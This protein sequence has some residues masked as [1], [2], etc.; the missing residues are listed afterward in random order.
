MKRLIFTFML[1][2]L[3]FGLFATQTLS[4]YIPTIEDDFADNRII[5]TLRQ[6]YSDVN[7]E[8]DTNSFRSANIISVED[9]ARESLTEENDFGGLTVV[10][11]IE[12]LMYITDPSKIINRETFTQI[13]L[14]ELREKCKENV[15]QVIEDLEKLDIVLAAEPYYNF[16]AEDLSTPNDLMFNQQWGLRGVNGIQAENA[17]D[18]VNNFGT[19][20]PRIKVGIFERGIQ[21]DHP[22][23]RVIPGNFT[24]A[25]NA[26]TDH[27]THVAGIIGAIADNSDGV[28][29]IAQVYIALLNR[30]EFVSS[31][32]WA[33][34]NDIRIVNASFRYTWNG[35]NAPWTVADREAIKVFGTNGGLLVPSA[36]NQAYNNDISDEV[37]FPAGYG[38][39]RN[40]PD[41]TNVITVGS[42]NE[43][44]QRSSF[45]N[46]GQNC[47]HIYAPGGNILST[48]PEDLWESNVPGCTQV[49]QG[50][51]RTSGT[52]M[53]AP[54]V[55][56]VAAL[57][58]SLNPYI[59]A[60]EIK[61]IMV[62]NGVNIN[63]QVPSGS[64]TIT[65]TVKRLNAFAA[66]SN[67][68]VDLSVLPLIAP[69]TSMV[70]EPVEYSVTVKN[71]GNTTASNYTVEFRRGN[72]TLFTQQGTPLEPGDSAVFTF[73]WTP[74]TYGFYHFYGHVNYSLDQ[75]P[76]NNTTSNMSVT[77]QTDF[78]A[79]STQGPYNIPNAIR[80][81]APGGRLELAGGWYNYPDKLSLKNKDF[82]LIGTGDESY[83]T[84]LTAW[85]EIEN[86]TSEAKIENIIFTPNWNKHFESILR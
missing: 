48:F 51:A 35:E 52:S 16:D 39:A 9:A 67:T 6:E 12:D 50:Y 28:A 7:K 30:S 46:Y 1:M 65:Q 3:V 13:L 19:T 62:N 14:F 70:H 55:S 77:V 69:E 26:N 25:S 56:G 22:D 79:I 47:V 37:Q 78:L 57:M 71:D 75:V 18:L 86:V 58:L 38:D 32:A 81:I 29:G 60:E 66:L 27:G 34:S 61:S 33:I 74:S 17:W 54:H 84:T 8:I 2:L 72:Q 68:I 43:N 42:I 49:A 11:S 80:L 21:I 82:H 36:G 53:A 59:T 76:S 15:L 40:F 24:P 73:T 20:N 45:S 44:G 85:F 64:G 31:L 23:L 4:R 63:I 5:V 10:E 41:I 83:P